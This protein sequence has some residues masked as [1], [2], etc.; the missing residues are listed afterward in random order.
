MAELIRKRMIPAVL[1]FVM[2]YLTFSQFLSIYQLS[3][4]YFAVALIGGIC[5]V[6][7]FCRRNWLKFLI[8]LICYLMGLYYYFPYDE[9]FSTQWLG[10]FSTHF[11]YGIHQ[12]M[13]GKL[14]YIP[15]TV[16]MC[17]MLLVIIVL[18]VLQIQFGR[19]LMCLVV[20]TGYLLMTVVFNRNN[21]SVQV[22][23]IL[24]CGLFY[25][26]NKKMPD[27]FSRKHWLLPLSI[28]MGLLIS[29]SFLSIQL[30]LESI[31]AGIIGGT[32]SV[33]NYF[34]EEGLYALINK[35][36]IPTASRSGFSENDTDLGGPLLD[37]NSVLFRAY[38]ETGHY[39]RVESKDF[40]SGKGW[41]KK[42]T[43]TERVLED[44]HL[45]YEDE[46]YRQNYASAQEI[47]LDFYHHGSYVPLPYGRSQITIIRGDEGLIMDQENHRVDFLQ[48]S[49]RSS[50]RLK[51][52]TPE[53][54]GRDLLAVPLGYPRLARVTDSEFQFGD[55]EEVPVN[56][57]QLPAELPER[58]SQLAENI[59]AKRSTLYDKVTAIEEYLSDNSDFIYSK[60]D[61]PFTPENKDYVDYFLFESKVGYCDNFSSSMV[62]L[63]RTLGIPARWTKGFAA[64]TRS[65]VEED[66]KTRTVYA[67]KNSDAHAWVE[68]YFEGYG[69]LPFEPTPTFNNPD[70]PA[71]TEDDVAAFE[72]AAASGAD[73]EQASSDSSEITENTRG[74]LTDDEASV[75]IGIDWHRVIR[76]GIYLGGTALVVF[77]A[78]LLH[79]YFFLVKTGFYLTFSKHPLL[80]VYPVL[81]QQAEKL[82]PRPEAEPLSQYA[83][84]LEEDFDSFEGRFIE[85]TGVYEEQFYGNVQVEDK[86]DKTLQQ[87]LWA[88]AG[89]LRKSMRRKKR[90]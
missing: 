50:I 55:I 61:T 11:F 56:Y 87:Q 70:R 20:T 66:G 72:S 13:E 22:L 58:V 64:G 4:G 54:S 80:V 53:Y 74:M 24:C 12:M 3:A 88:I 23:T 45:F 1:T 39:W 30:P 18:A 21:L 40:Y 76:I 31:K 60:T 85:L 77:G 7:A 6:T 5:L 29:F 78:Y 36:G 82:L 59:T 73:E 81:L 79:K 17:L 63:L 2:L 51:W 75:D 48:P 14:G 19:W 9:M 52:E 68:V 26:L 37:E 41:E 27:S 65:L 8:Y 84:R 16:A 34:N 46:G 33:R 90:S 10:V 47:Q 71:I 32:S 83:L 57:L 89:M 69:W 25:Y 43:N 44:T 42:S 67:V 38:Q 62:V 15:E 86:D 28:G 35:Y 49:E